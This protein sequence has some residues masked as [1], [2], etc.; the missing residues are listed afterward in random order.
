MSVMELERGAQDAVEYGREVVNDRTTLESLEWFN[1]L[2][3]FRR[4]VG[5]ASLLRLD[6]NDAGSFKWRG[7]FRKIDE[8]VRRSD[9]AVASLR[10][11]TAG[12]A[13]KGAAL[14]ARAHHLPI[15]VF[16][17]T[18]TP[19]EK[20]Q[21][22]LN[23]WPN[24]RLN[25]VVTG[26]TLA[27]SQ[28]AAKENFTGNFIPPFDDPSVIDGQKTVLDDVL[29]HAPD[30]KRVIVPI[31]GGSLIAGV[32][33]RRAEL[34]LED[35][36]EVV[37]V[38]AAGSN[39]MGLS[40]ASGQI[41]PA[42]APNA[43]FGGLK[44]ETPGEHTF[45]GVQNHSKNLTILSANTNSV[46]EMAIYFEQLHQPNE[47]F[48]LEPSSIVALQGLRSMFEAGQLDNNH[49]VVLGTGHNENLGNLYQAPQLSH[50]ALGGFIGARSN[51]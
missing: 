30:A 14:A 24:G 9:G 10:T 37:G 44:V 3:L 33:K 31:G 51:R 12:N 21:A 45:R 19:A 16:V 39:G 25:L 8:I 17:P 6:Y 28:V 4:L 23:A 15:D 47:P 42:H 48:L 49:T 13:G 29:L 41:M 7:A 46:R 40:L 18:V 22:I 5:H 34:Q 20:Q 38:E 1:E 27:D 32:L 35:D 43:W 26:D 2:N 50:A 36:I 11:V